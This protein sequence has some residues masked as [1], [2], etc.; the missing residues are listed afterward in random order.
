MNKYILL[1]CI[2][3]IT[4]VFA[5]ETPFTASV[6]FVGMGM[7]YREYDNSGEILD[8]EESSYLDLGGVELNFVYQLSED[9]LSSSELELNYMILGGA[10]KYK[11][12]YISSGLPYGSVVSTTYNRVID[13][14]ILYKRN[15]Y[16]K[17]DIIVSYGIGVGYREWKRSLSVLQ[18]EVYSWNSFRPML[19][20]SYTNEKLN[21]GMMLEY[22][23][24][25]DTKMLASDLNHTFTL[26]GA[27]ILEVSFPFTYMY[28]ESLNF[29][30]E[31]VVQ[32]QSIIE[33]DRLYINSTSYYYEP[34]S[35]A[36]N[37][38]IKFGA[39]YKF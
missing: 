4:N 9:P 11:G 35:K 3:I 26:G 23:Y 28:D 21:L 20:I 39:G 18:V 33:S 1:L 25:F 12:S 6:S 13:I 7:D 16:L 22:Q 36:Y 38:Y 2:L 34:E 17:N 19:G 32:R 27:D 15:Q 14:D 31:A 10:T 29:F 37:S 8:S 24:G 5:K 30:L